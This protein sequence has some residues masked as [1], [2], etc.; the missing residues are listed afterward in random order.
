MLKCLYNNYQKTFNVSNVCCRLILLRQLIEPFLWAMF[1]TVGLL[2]PTV[3]IVQ[4]MILRFCCCR[5]SRASKENSITADVLDLA[6]GAVEAGDSDDFTM[7]RELAS[8]GPSAH[9]YDYIFI[10]V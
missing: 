1:L 4:G 5:R 10:F 8:P 3:D 7:A 6:S 2:L 9:G